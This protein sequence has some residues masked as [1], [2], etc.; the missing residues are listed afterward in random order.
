KKHR[1]RTFYFGAD[2]VEA[3]KRFA[4]EWD[5]I[6]AGRTPRPRG[7]DALTVGDLANHFSTAKRDRVD[8]GE[9]SGGMWG[10]YYHCCEAVVGSFGRDRRVP[11]LRPADFGRLR[12]AA[13]KRLGPVALHKFV[14]M[15][16]TVFKFAFEAELIDAPPRYG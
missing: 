15:T 7:G 8:A 2:R 13:S 12:A 3:L 1:G 4:N 14:T 5:D 6:V 16:R 10:E 9:L 11:D